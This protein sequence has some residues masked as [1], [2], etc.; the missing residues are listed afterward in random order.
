MTPRYQYKA[1]FRLLVTMRN[2]L[3]FSKQFRQYRLF[4]SVQKIV[5]NIRQNINLHLISLI[6]SYLVYVLARSIFS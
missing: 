6:I 1:L 3:F 4:H 2:H 5:A